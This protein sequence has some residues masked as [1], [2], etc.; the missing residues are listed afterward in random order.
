MIG[1][2]G[3]AAA[4]LLLCAALLAEAAPFRGASA[5]KAP[6]RPLAVNASDGDFPDRV[7]VTWNHVSRAEGYRVYRAARPGGPYEIIGAMKPN[8]RQFDDPQPCGSRRI[9]YKV[10]AYNGWGESAHSSYNTGHTAPCATPPPKKPPS[11]TA[12]DGAYRDRIRVTWSA[13]RDADQYAVYR[14]GTANGRYTLVATLKANRRYYD[15]PR[16]CGGARFFYKVSAINAGGESPLS[17]GNRGHTAA[18]RE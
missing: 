9:Y 5:G 14:S 17:T 7:R 13:V 16:D 4:C 3:R 1:F 18:C 2:K 10:S 6:P 12:S 11:V 15:D 8:V